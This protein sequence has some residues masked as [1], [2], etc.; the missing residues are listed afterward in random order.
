MNM[1]IVVLPGDNI[2]QEGSEIVFKDGSRFLFGGFISRTKPTETGEGQMFVYD[3]EASDYSF[4]FGSKTARRAYS[5]TTLKVIVEDL[6]ATYIDAS[7][8]FTTTNVATGPT[9]D[10]ITFDHI[11]IRKCFEKLQKLTG[12]VWYVDYQKNLFFTTQIATPAPESFTDSSANFYEVNISY[13]TAQVR[14]SVICIGSDEGEQSSSYSEQSFTGDGETRS[15]QLDDKP[16]YVVFIK[17]NGVSKQFSLDAN[18]RDTDI[19]TYSFSGSSFRQTTAQTTLTGSDTIT[20]RYYPRVPIVVQ[21]TSASSIAF[22]STLDGGDGVYE[23]TIKEPAITSKASASDRAQQE[24][25][26]FSMPLVNGVIKTRTGLLAGGSI[27]TPG[28]V[29]TINLPTHGITTD[30]AFLIQEVNIT[31]REDGTNT[32][33][34]YEIRFGGKIVGVQ[35]FLESL[36]SENGEVANVDNIVTIEQISDE[37]EV[38]DS[39]ALT[40]TI[41]TPPY[42]YTSGTPVGKW[43][44]SEW[45]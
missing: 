39:Q 1:Q 6:M 18:E 44:L 5:N 17:V 15:W 45:S 24:L 22:F 13:D 43:N 32:E 34:E 36:V 11:S 9:I 20:I 25:D 33:Y 28:Q 2:P 23:Y 30:S 42:H 10:S 16:S 40:H 3:I 19:F 7:Y 21:K 35:E 27:F 14:N 12:Y 41:A 31:L 38:D 4:I 29:L 26:E 8:G 37:E